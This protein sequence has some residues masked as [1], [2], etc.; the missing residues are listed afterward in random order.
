MRHEFHQS[1]GRITLAPLA[2]DDVEKMRVLRN[3]NTKNFF[4][5]ASITARAQQSWYQKYLRTPDDYMFSVYLNT[6]QQWVGAVGI[7]AVDQ[8]ARRGEF[9]RLLIDKD[10]T[11]EHGLGVDVTLAA[12]RFAVDILRLHTIVLEVYSD[13]LPAVKTYL[14]A[15]FS[16]YSRI[17]DN[18]N[19]E[20]ICM[21]YNN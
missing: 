16:E 10:N 14:K 1:Y 11:Q 19:R 9:G 15:G 6:T 20:I 13:N 12:C 4:D 3:N 8:D 18:E 2:A 17:Y 5:S 7:Y 21:S